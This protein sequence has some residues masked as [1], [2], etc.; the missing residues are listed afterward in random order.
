MPIHETAD[1]FHHHTVQSLEAADFFAC[2]EE[3]LA[4]YPN[5]VTSEIIPRLT[6]ME[7]RWHPLGFAVF[8]IAVLKDDSL[9]K[10]SSLRL[11]VWPEGLRKSHSLERPA[12]HDHAWHLISRVLTT[13]P[14]RDTRYNIQTVSDAPR[15]EG[16]RIKRG[17]R[18]VFRAHYPPEPRGLQTD[19][20][21]AQVTPI[22]KVVVPSGQYNRINAGEY[23][24]DM[25]PIGCTVATL[26]LD[27]PKLTD[28]PHVIVDGPAD[29]IQIARPPIPPED[30]RYIQGVLQNAVA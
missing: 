6:E 23:H 2:A 30:L 26:C 15:T 29:T 16:E 7:G 12:I 18:R 19:G 27:S 21:C 17:L 3:F 11:H 24:L 25:I 28:G 20:T 13:E 5:R 8:P 10:G 4:A 14:Y 1:E 22:R 9:L